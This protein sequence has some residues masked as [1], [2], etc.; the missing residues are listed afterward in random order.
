[1]VFAFNVYARERAG[2]NIRRECWLA[3]VLSVV[4]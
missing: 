2:N 1:L 3:V 4:R